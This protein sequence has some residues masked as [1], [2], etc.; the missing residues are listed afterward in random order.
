M[1]AAVKQYD[2]RMDS[3]KR[4]TLRNASFEYYH[5]EEFAD[6]RI[7]LEPRELVAPFQISENSLHM[8]DQSMQNLQ[9]GKVSESVDLSDFEE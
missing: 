8:L 7:L 3:R 6:G 5:V 4:I 2:A 9:Q 1:Q